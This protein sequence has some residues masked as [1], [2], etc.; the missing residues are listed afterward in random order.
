MYPF[1]PSLSLHFYVRKYPALYSRPYFG[2]ALFANVSFIP[3]G[4]GSVLVRFFLMW[5]P[6]LVLTLF[7]PKKLPVFA[8]AF[9]YIL[10][11]LW[12]CFISLRC[13]HLSWYSRTPLGIHG[14]HSLAWYSR[15]PSG[16]IR[17]QLLA[18]CSRA[19]FGSVRLDLLSVFPLMFWDPIRLYLLQVPCA[20]SS[21][22]IG[23][24]RRYSVPCL[25]L[26]CA[27]CADPEVWSEDLKIKPKAWYLNLLLP[28]ICRH[29]LLSRSFQLTHSPF[30]SPSLCFALPH[31]LPSFISSSST[32][33]LLPPFL[34]L[35]FFFLLSLFHSLHASLFPF[36][37]LKKTINFY[38]PRSAV[39]AWGDRHCVY[40]VLLGAHDWVRCVSLLCTLLRSLGGRESS[41]CL[42]C[43]HDWVCCRSLTCTWSRSLGARG[44]SWYLRSALLA[45]D[46]SQ[47]CSQASESSCVMDWMFVCI[48][49]VTPKWCGACVHE[50]ALHDCAELFFV[51]YK[52]LCGV[53]LG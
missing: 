43:S 11:P 7:R 48:H 28:T 51:S 21:G 20:M 32:F 37:H 24:V 9:T 31:S 44:L 22:S 23:F 42:L 46:W 53:F 39:W 47:L 5:G 13:E 25:R 12:S 2:R 50:I 33:L 49:S 30:P 35:L 34:S 6:L 41:M 27:L 19:L 8:N 16:C 26:N 29:I 1:R 4:L 17:C 15:T 3:N 14:C 18:R 38:S 52:F 45:R 10:I 40:L 36:L